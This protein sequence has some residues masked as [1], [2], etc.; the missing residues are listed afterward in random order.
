MTAAGRGFDQRAVEAA[1][2]VLPS[3]IPDSGTVGRG[4]LSAGTLGAGIINPAI[5]A[6]TISGAALYTNPGLRAMQ[7]IL[8]QRPGGAGS[9]R[10]LIEQLAPAAGAVGTAT[11]MLSN[12]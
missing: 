7:A 8:T 11:G 5:P 4:L 10:A 12:K 6:A 1:Q 9:A 2:D 3:K